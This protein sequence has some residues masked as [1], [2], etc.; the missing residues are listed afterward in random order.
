MLARAAT[1]LKPSSM[2]WICGF[3]KCCDKP[4]ADAPP[5]QTT[6]FPSKTALREQ[7]EED[8]PVS[9]DEDGMLECESHVGAF[10]EMHDSDKQIITCADG[11]VYH[12]QLDASNFRHGHGVCVWSNG[13]IIY[14]GQWQHD[15]QSGE[16]K[17]AWGDGRGYRGQFAHGLFEGRGHMEWHTAK[18]LMVYDG[19]YAA[20]KKHGRGRFTWPDGRVYDGDWH[21]G[22]RSGKAT[23]IDVEGK[24]Y[25]GLWRANHLDT[26]VQEGEEK[27]DGPGISGVGPISGM[28]HSARPQMPSLQERAGGTASM[29]IVH[30]ADAYQPI[31]SPDG[32]KAPS[33]SFEWVKN[34]FEDPPIEDPPKNV[35]FSNQSDGGREG[36]R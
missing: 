21:K 7:P 18:G 31:E 8:V 33:S 13:A 17:Q 28:C 23:F 10:H 16:G 34:L 15:E 22:E 9:D 11:S 14:E 19:Q 29:E 25:V 5:L 6:K 35:S 26:W 32:A 24:R 3:S 1:G 2:Q 20:G 4:N 27:Q 36:Q 12:G 30:L